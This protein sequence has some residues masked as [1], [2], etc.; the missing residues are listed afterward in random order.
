M[1]TIKRLL[2]RVMITAT[3]CGV[4][5][6]SPRP[7]AAQDVQPYAQGE[8]L[9]QFAP[10]LVSAQAEA[11]AVQ[12]GAV[13]VEPLRRSQRQGLADS[14]IDRWYHIILALGVDTE[15]A[16]QRFANNPA[17]ERAEIPYLFTRVGILARRL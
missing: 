17:V 14:P 13:T 10:S 8:L 1:L 15:Q 5:P 9:V 7:V 3:L 11:V 4:I 6:L 12:L 2:L 16:L